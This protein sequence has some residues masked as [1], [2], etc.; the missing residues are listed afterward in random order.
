MANK[1][2]LINL[3]TDLAKGLKQRTEYACLKRDQYLNLVLRHEAERLDEEVPD[4]NSDAA[5][6]YIAQELNSLPRKPTN[7]MLSEETIQAVNDA[8]E[9]KN[10]PRDAFIHRVLLFL[11]LGPKSLD[12]IIEVDWTW[13]R[14]RLLEQGPDQLYKLLIPSTLLTIGELVEG[15][16]FWYARSCLDYLREEDAA[17]PTLL[18]AF[19]RKH[20]FDA[21]VPN[22]IGFNC[23]IPDNLVVGTPE[24]QKQTEEL[25]EFL[26]MLGRS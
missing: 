24:H 21:T 12:D 19:L 25:N 6:A 3:W 17:T 20:A 18:G 4:R 22:A 9:R 1:K 13:A 8:C 23:Y 15:D 7:L 10:L 5:R 2:I 26:A 14:H 11:L 16:P